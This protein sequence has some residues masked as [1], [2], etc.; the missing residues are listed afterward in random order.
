[1]LTRERG[2]EPEWNVNDILFVRRNYSTIVIVVPCGL[3][4]SLK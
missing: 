2:L 3:P 1:M 4:K